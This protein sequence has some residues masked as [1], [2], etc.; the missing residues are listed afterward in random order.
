MIF[1]LLIL[2]LTLSLSLA[3]TARNNKNNKFVTVNTEPNGCDFENYAKCENPQYI[4]NRA[5]G[6]YLGRRDVYQDNSIDAVLNYNYEKFCVSKCFITNSAT[7]LVLDHYVT[8]IEKVGNTVIRRLKIYVIFSTIEK[9]G[10]ASQMWAVKKEETG[11]YSIISEKY[12][13][14][15]AL[16]S[17][18][19]Y[20]PDEGLTLAYF[21]V[22][23][24]KQ[25][26]IIQE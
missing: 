4:I 11:F 21:D 9:S 5:T 3:F 6:F 23:D 12:G 14:L 18:N 20:D 17:V 24:T 22:N 8:R 7:D 25:Q 26:W 13:N 10:N 15:L 16:A 19:A 2:V 1:K